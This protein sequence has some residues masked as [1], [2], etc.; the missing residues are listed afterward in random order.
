[1]LYICAACKYMFQSEKP[2][3]QCPDCGKT[4]VRTATPA[5]EQEYEERMRTMENWFDET[6]NQSTISQ[7]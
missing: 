6:G 1:M 3:D 4:A 2:V 5:E 7:N